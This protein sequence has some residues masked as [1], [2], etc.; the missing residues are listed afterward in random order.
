M[1]SPGWGSE[2]PVFRQKKHYPDGKREKSPLFRWLRSFTPLR[3]W[4]WC[5]CRS[6]WMIPSA[7]H[8]TLWRE[9]YCILQGAVP[10][11]SSI[12]KT[13]RM[14]LMLQ[15]QKILSSLEGSLK[16]L[17]MV[18]TLAGLPQQGV[19]V[20]GTRQ[21]CKTCC[22]H[23]GIRNH[24]NIYKPVLQAKLKWM[25]SNMKGYTD[26]RFQRPQHEHSFPICCFY[27][28]TFQPWKMKV[29]RLERNVQQGLFPQ[30]F[31]N[32]T[33][34]ARKQTEINTVYSMWLICNFIL[35]CRINNYISRWN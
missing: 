8:S 7:D 31:T 27:K 19:N 15:V 33:N 9:T 1:Y 18:K 34:V 14:L 16:C 24:Q 25:N 11:P 28:E 35:S 10:K 2:W 23:P 30:G 3:S 13:F 6:V 17:K 20:T 12:M 32:I 29:Q 21:V 4:P 26:T 5:S 22:K